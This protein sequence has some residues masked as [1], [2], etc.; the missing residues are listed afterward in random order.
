MADQSKQADSQP[1]EGSQPEEDPKEAI[2][3]RLRGGFDTELILR[4]RVPVPGT[5]AEA[6]MDSDPPQQQQ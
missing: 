1:E 2:L 6:T 4:R 3:R 5:N